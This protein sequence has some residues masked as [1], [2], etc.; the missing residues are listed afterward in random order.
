MLAVTLLAVQLAAASTDVRPA[1][2][3]PKDGMELPIK[4]TRKIEFETEEVTWPSLDVSPDGKK[5]VFELLGD[6]YELPIEGGK[7]KLLVGGQSYDG[8]PRFS[9]DGSHIAFVSDRSGSDN[10]WLCN[11]DGTGL[12]ALS[13][14]RDAAW[15]SPAFTPDGNYVL[16]CRAQG[17]LGPYTLQ[18]VDV[19]GGSGLS[20][21]P[22]ALQPGTL[23][24][25]RVG[26]PTPNR[27]GITASMDGRYFFFTERKGPWQYNQDS[28]AQC[29]V[30]RMDR[31][32]GKVENVTNEDGGAMRPLVSPD[33]KILL[34]FTRYHNKTGLKALNLTTG[35]T[36]MV[37]YPV[38][39]DDMESRATRDLMP[40][41]AFLPGA[42]EI[43]LG[44]NGKIQRLDIQ[45]GKATVIPFKAS[46]SQMIGEEVH[47]DYHLETSPT[48]KAKIAR[49]AVLSPDG[50]TIAF[51][52]FQKLYTMKLAGGTPKRVTD[53]GENEFQPSWSPDGRSLVFATWD[54][55]KGGTVSVA[56]PSGAVRAITNYRA[57]Y[58]KPIFT[59]DGKN[60]VFTTGTTLQGQ[61][62]AIRQQNPQADLELD[63][64]EI[65]RSPLFLAENLKIV[66]VTGGEPKLLMHAP[67][68]D[69]FFGKDP[70]RLFVGSGAGLSSM[71]LDGTDVHEIA[72]FTGSTPRSGPSEIALSPDGSRALVDIDFKFYEIN[73]PQTG[74]AVVVGTKGGAVPSKIVAKEGGEN[75]TW[76]PDGKGAYWTFG[77]KLYVQDLKAD[78]PTQ[79]SLNV[80][81][82]RS[83]PHGKVLLRGARLIT[84]RGDEVIKSGDILVVDN[85]I[86]DVGP[87][88]SF[89]MPK[90]A[91]VI[92]MAGKTISPGYV[93][94]HS[95]WFGN[96]STGF[97]QS[98]AY[99]LNFAYGVTTQRDPQS[100]SD[101]IY[102]FAGAIEAGLG[103]GPRIYTTGPGVFNGPG[104]EDKD[105]VLAHLKRYRD[106]Y[107][108][109]TIKEYVTGDRMVIEY[110]AMACKAL[111][112][113]PTTE[114]ALEIKR[115][116]AEASAGISGHEHALPIELH[117]DVAKFI[118][119]THTYYT[120]TLIVSYGGPFG[121]NYWF[122]NYD[123]VHEPKVT[124][125]MPDLA[126]DSLIRRRG[127]WGLPEEYAFTMVAEG[128]K[129]VVDAGGKVCAGCHGEFQGL[130]SHWEMW[131]LASGGMTPLQVLR[132]ASLNGA[133]AIGLAQ[134]IGSLTPGKYA[135]LVIYDKNPLENIRN[136]N[137]IHWVMKNGE[138]FDTSTMDE[139][140]PVAKKLPTPYWNALK[141]AAANP[142]TGK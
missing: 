73:L 49:D 104:T 69:Y 28:G 41:Y 82:P 90:D 83:T 127:F 77:N 10:I 140:Y 70:E 96:P 35:D 71:R 75:L 2:E 107:D 132:C 98:W 131:M 111:G 60:I 93:D 72:R 53:A 64:A 117:D 65:G 95:H 113:T 97:P 6:L 17:Y 139:V 61:D 14:G 63:E 124:A 50:Q 133:E 11:A 30:F 22:A 103:V 7:A 38:D 68:G 56:D 81:L 121:E 89:P 84:M 85:K 59:P 5:I 88:G 13:Q 137:T 33:G 108:T 54:P 134:D 80:E 66:P 91:K 114:G 122:T 52:A 136:T 78:K 58:S 102:D 76:T 40:G 24:D 110:V 106:A 43:V 39:R 36:R 34:Y 87:S 18:M 126:K 94:T 130:G 142:V 123:I 20:F 44:L 12:K 21:G 45:T 47:F 16:G 120:P 86:T 128:C 55:V 27:M 92:K 57:Y 141:M 3:K 31:S 138:L 99:L 67:Q 23:N 109:K 15:L 25:P 100:G 4:P 42:K 101:A 129:K 105:D 51:C 115:Y 116:L 125:F 29:Q 8:M 79:Y 62:T 9:P 119:K 46:V 19:R 135:D 1:P 74:E 48:V 32:N 26:R 37:A 118:A 112:L